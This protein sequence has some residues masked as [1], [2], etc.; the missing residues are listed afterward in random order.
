L[1]P[2]I[3]KQDSE[4]VEKMFLANSFDFRIVKNQQVPG[5]RKS[6]NGRIWGFSAASAVIEN[7]GTLFF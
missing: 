5:Q 6:E 3:F 4:P 1:D 2:Q 7:S